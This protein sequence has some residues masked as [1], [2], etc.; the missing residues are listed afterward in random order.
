MLTHSPRYVIGCLQQNSQ[1]SP[2]LVGNGTNDFV[3][4]VGNGDDFVQTG[5]GTGKLHVAGTGRKTLHLG[6]GWTQV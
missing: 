1:C 3:S 2:C 5:T 6:S 4:L